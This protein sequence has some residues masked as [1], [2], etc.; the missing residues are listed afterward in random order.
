MYALL[1]RFNVSAGASAA[2]TVLSA[3]IA[4]ADTPECPVLSGQQKE[5]LVELH[6]GSFELQ[7]FADAGDIMVRRA[8]VLDFN[9]DMLVPNWVAWRVEGDFLETPDRAGAWKSFKQDRPLRDALGRAFAVV[10]ADYTHSGYHRGHMAPYFVSGGDRDGDGLYAEDDVDDAC[11]VYEINY[12]SNM[13]PQLPHFNTYGGAWYDLESQT[14]LRGQAGA[15]YNIIAGN[16]Y[17]SEDVEFIGANTRKIGVPD[18]LFKVIDDG[19]R[20]ISYLFFQEARPD[21]LIDAY[22]AD[23]GCLPQ[24]NV[25]ACI[26]DAAVIE[27]V[28]PSLR[29]SP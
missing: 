1:N 28:F 25:S 15:E 9:P 21:F 23:V 6:L 13:S 3:Q 10:A 18:A 26:V 8:Y 19:H 22:G 24:E 2:A 16:L 11:T 14:R 4:T 7:G 20:Q 12:M 17:L 5:D 29:L 27:S